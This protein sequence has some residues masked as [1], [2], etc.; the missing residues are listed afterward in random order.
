MSLSLTDKQVLLTILLDI[1]KEQKLSL[2]SQKYLIQLQQEL[3][4]YRSKA[5]NIEDMLCLS[6]GEI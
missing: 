1:Q 6:Y 2:F 5:E 3:K 4:E